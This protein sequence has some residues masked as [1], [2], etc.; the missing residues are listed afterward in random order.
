MNRE[1]LKQILPQRE[2]MLLVDEAWKNEDGTAGGKYTVRG[3]EFFVQ[4]H[5]PGNPVVPGVILC[6]MAAQCSCML[7]ADKVQGK[8]TMFTGLDHVKFKTPVRPGDTVVFKS[9][10]VR[11]MSFI[12]KVD[13]VGEVNGRMAVSL[14]FTIALVDPD[15]VNNM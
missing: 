6:E 9:T 2:P 1:E 8:I 15:A 5:F 14:E 11:A 10:H 4:G 7:M 3:D 13:V 12:H